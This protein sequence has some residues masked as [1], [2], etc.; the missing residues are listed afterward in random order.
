[1]ITEGAAPNGT[2]QPGLA[3]LSF[4]R[5]GLADSDRIAEIMHGEPLPEAV[6]LAFGSPELARALGYELVRMPGSPEGW[7]HTVL[8][9]LNGEAVG[10]L[11]ASGDHVSFTTFI[12]PG[13]VLRLM[14]IFGPFKFLRGLPRI[15]AKARLDFNHPPGAYTVHE[16]HVDPRCRN[17]GVGGALLD[18]AETEARRDGHPCMSLTTTTSNPARR[19]Y[20]R[21]GFRV[22]ETRT[23]AA[24]QRYT[25]IEGRHLMLKELD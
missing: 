20:E 13:L 7:E 11:Q 1:M 6:G 10:V 24:F 16:L 18:Y 8:S 19:L 3:G 5:A 22:V 14:R 9:V 25:G 4:R 15:K 17:R 12:T 2:A 23:D 21:H